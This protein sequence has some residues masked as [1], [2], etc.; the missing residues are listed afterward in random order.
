ML[1]NPT[2]YSDHNVIPHETAR[3]HLTSPLLIRVPLIRRL[4]LKT[5]PNTRPVRRRRLVAETDLARRTIARHIRRQTGISSV[6]HGIQLSRGARRQRAAV[7]AADHDGL[8]LAL[9]V[10]DLA[11]NHALGDALDDPPA[12]HA[13]DVD[14]HETDVLDTPGEL[15][16]DGAGL[17]APFVADGCAGCCAAGGEDLLAGL[18]DAVAD[19]GPGDHGLVE[20][21]RLV[22]LVVCAVWVQALVLGVLVAGEASCKVLGVLSD[23]ANGL[24]RDTSQACCQGVDLA[25]TLVRGGLEDH[26]LFVWLGLVDEAFCAGYHHVAKIAGSSHDQARSCCRVLYQGRVLIR[27][28][29]GESEIVLGQGLD[30]D[31]LAVSRDGDLDWV[32]IYVSGEN[33]GR[34]NWVG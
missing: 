27:G 22:V 21:T 23:R 8:L 31:A 16:G 32:C 29:A 17:L 7:A 12:R 20:Q 18:G 13:R 4:P 34:I 30:V 26:G 14:V 33:L 19:G 28:V 5:L 1:R 11:D 9:L 10:L 25:D 6:V 2:V 15:G 24:G 3:H